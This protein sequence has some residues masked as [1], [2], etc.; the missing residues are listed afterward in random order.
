[1]VVVR[2]HWAR[3]PEGR[4]IFTASGEQSSRAQGSGPCCVQLLRRGITRWG[5]GEAKQEPR[6][7]QRSTQG[8][9]ADS[10][11]GGKSPI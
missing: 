6:S 9:R 3:V 4:Q 11:T 5:T 1:V 8:R 7:T 2:V 10:N